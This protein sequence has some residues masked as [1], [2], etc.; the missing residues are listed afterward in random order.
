MYVRFTT[1]EVD[2]FKFFFNFHRNM[3]Y[4]YPINSNKA[5]KRNTSS[6]SANSSL[7]ILSSFGFISG[8]CLTETNFSWLNISTLKLK[9]SMHG[10][11]HKPKFRCGFGIS[12]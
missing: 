10:L 8:K 6:V 12:K 7:G 3:I 2:S 1:P 4:H 9:I 11:M 5:V